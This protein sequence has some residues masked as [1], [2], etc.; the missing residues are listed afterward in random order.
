LNPDYRIIAAGGSAGGVE[1]FGILLGGLP[2][3]PGAAIVLVQHQHRYSDTAGLAGHLA[4]RSGWPVQVA[5]DK[6]IMEPGR[7]Y[8]APANY[9][10]LLERDLTFAL[11]VDEKVHHCRPSIDVFFESVA[12]ALGN[13]AIGVVLSGANR[14]GAEGLQKIKERG[15][16]TLVQEPASAESGTMPESAIRAGAPH[17]VL[18]PAA[19]AALLAELVKKVGQ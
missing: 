9:H 13:R 12:L 3:S 7:L 1:A 18:A 16:L 2:V 5:G 4:A 10:L 11:S 17:H 8:L 6:E 15:G 19:M 14:D